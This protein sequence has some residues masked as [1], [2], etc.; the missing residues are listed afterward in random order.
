MLIS[1]NKIRKDYNWILN[2]SH[3]DELI[4]DAE[5]DEK[6]D[7]MN[8]KYDY[9]VC[10]ELSDLDQ[11]FRVLNYWGVYEIPFSI[12][13]RFDEEDPCVLT[14]FLMNL[15]TDLSLKLYIQKYIRF[16]SALKEHGTFCNN[17]GRYGYLDMLKWGIV[18]KKFSLHEV[19]TQASINGHVHILEWLH[20]NNYKFD[21]NIFYETVKHGQYKSTLWLYNHNMIT[22]HKKII[23]GFALKS[24]NIELINFIYS[25]FSK[26]IGTDLDVSITK[27]SKPETFDWLCGK[28]FIPTK[29][30]LDSAARYGSVEMIEW[31]LNKGIR[32]DNR[33]YDSAIGSRIVDNVK[34]LIDNNIQPNNDNFYSSLVIGNIEIMELLYEEGCRFD[35]TID[36]IF[37]EHDIN[38]NTIKWMFD[39][40]YVPKENVINEAMYRES[41]ESIE[42]MLDN[43]FPFYEDELVESSI[44]SDEIEKAKLLY[45][46]GYKFKSENYVNAGLN[47][48]L[49]M[50]DFLYG[51]GV[52]PDSQAYIDLLEANNVV[53]IFDWLYNHGCEIPEFDDEILISSD[54]VILW[55]NNKK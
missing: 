26:E 28:G 3:F 21:Q 43:N 50:M 32:A 33:T 14:D 30:T 35:D 7:L 27:T 36:S 42:W 45:D 29:S 1:L 15:L 16:V 6:N 39:H 54:D 41:I 52:E 5:E 53:K 23:M 48:N 13:N 34:I 38:I 46:L 25:S 49:D 19:S 24:D 20:K 17:M 31:C 10:N 2:S 8:L 44:D 37:N 11:I 18:E 40:E 9:P 51:I 12:L 22:G 47:G 4:E 55:L